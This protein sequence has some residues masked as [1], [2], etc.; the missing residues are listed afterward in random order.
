MQKENQKIDIYNLFKCLFISN[1]FLNF[2]IKYILNTI[3][4]DNLLK[5]RTAKHCECDMSQKHFLMLQSSQLDQIWTNGCK[6]IFYLQCCKIPQIMI[7]F[8]NNH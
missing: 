1:Y 7:Q 4:I 6:F 5:I 8:A 2:S 3:L